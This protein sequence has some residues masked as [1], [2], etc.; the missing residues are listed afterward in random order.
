MIGSVDATKLSTISGVS[1]PV[2]MWPASGEYAGD[3]RETGIDCI[4]I[5]VVTC[6][7]NA[8]IFRAEHTVTGDEVRALLARGV[9]SLRLWAPGSKG[10]R[11][12][13]PAD[14]S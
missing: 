10:V 11:S 2:I 14:Q 9:G 12:G 3:Q 13:P 8:L 4:S 6:L 7:G 1:S 5:I